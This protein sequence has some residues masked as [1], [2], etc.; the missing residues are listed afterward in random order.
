MQGMSSNT[1]RLAAIDAGTGIYSIAE[2]GDSWANEPP[3]LN[4]EEIEDTSPLYTHVKESLDTSDAIIKIFS[5][6]NTGIPEGENTLYFPAGNNDKDN[7]PLVYACTD[8]DKPV[9]IEVKKE[10]NTYAIS[11]GDYNCFA[12]V[13]NNLPEKEQYK[14]ILKNLL[15]IISSY[16]FIF[17]KTG[18]KP[19]TMPKRQDIWLL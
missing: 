2:Y 8:K 14:K 1:G 12:L 3:A 18:T 10:N 19:D 13:Y 7:I 6:I 9:K 16:Y 15:K 11:P 4:V 17:Y 5:V